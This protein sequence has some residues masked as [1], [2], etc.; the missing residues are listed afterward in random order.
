MCK[1]RKSILTFGALSLIE[2]AAEDLTMR[3]FGALSMIKTLKNRLFWCKNYDELRT[4]PGLA[5]RAVAAPGRSHPPV[6]GH[7]RRPPARLWP[8]PGTLSAGWRIAGA[9]RLHATVGRAPTERPVLRPGIRPHRTQPHAI[10][11]GFDGEQAHC[12]LQDRRS[13]PRVRSGRRDQ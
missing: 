10:R 4:A 9:H 2:S 13:V 1:I 7:R 3:S 6:S 8:E 12:P 5:G 11:P